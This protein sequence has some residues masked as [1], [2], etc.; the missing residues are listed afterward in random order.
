YAA[1]RP[2]FGAGPGTAVIAALL[3]WVMIGLLHALS[4]SPMATTMGAPRQ[5]YTIGTLIALVALPL[6]ALAG[7][8]FYTES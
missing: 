2:R 1:I 7:A 6:G 5:I 3:M 4:E 8:K